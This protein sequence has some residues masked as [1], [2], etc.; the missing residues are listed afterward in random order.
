MNEL[1]IPEKLTPAALEGLT[2]HVELFPDREDAND[3]IKTTR[4]SVAVGSSWEAYGQYL[5]VNLS[6]CKAAAKVSKGKCSIPGV[7]VRS[8]QGISIRSSK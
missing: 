1:A 3:L 5:L 8:K 6:A 7:T 2:V 4:T